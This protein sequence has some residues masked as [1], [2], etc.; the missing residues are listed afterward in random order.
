MSTVGVSALE[1]AGLTCFLSRRIFICK[2]TRNI[3][4]VDNKRYKRKN[5]TML[6]K[7][8]MPCQWELKCTS[9]VTIS[10]ARSKQELKGYYV[11]MANMSYLSVIPFLCLCGSCDWVG[12]VLSATNFMSVH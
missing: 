10:Q 12:R 8:L 2:P 5:A 7:W 9:Y 11:L 1:E 4:G 3:K 6:N